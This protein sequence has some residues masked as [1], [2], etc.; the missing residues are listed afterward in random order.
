MKLSGGK[1]SEHSKPTPQR[2]KSAARAKP[3]EQAPRQRKPQRRAPGEQS[4]GSAGRI[5][6]IV[7]LALIAAVMIAA[8]AGVNYVGKINTIFPNVRVDGIDVG[9][10]TLEETADTLTQ[11]GYNVMGDDAVTVL[12]P[13][14][15]SL[16]IRADEVCSETSTADIAL[17]AYHACKDGSALNDALTYLRCRF[18]GGMDLDSNSARTVDAAAVHASVQAAAKE[19]QLALLSS[20]LRIGE[21][22]VTLVK[23]A[24][25]VQIDTEALSAQIVKAFENR[26]YA[27]IRYETEIQ[28]DS[29]FDMQ[30][31]YDTVYSLELLVAFIQAYVF[32]LLSAIYFG[33]AVAEEHEPE[34]VPAA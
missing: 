32:T 27:P 12:L 3:A 13:L 11:H 4:G 34:K 9:G 16:T 26:D 10:R 30:S 31:L 1:S 6:L 23:G 22:S 8:A 24:T 21:D 25:G 14:D 2:E 17:M 20:D 33:M 28:T 15:V 5:V 29:E 18:G 7:V 19:V